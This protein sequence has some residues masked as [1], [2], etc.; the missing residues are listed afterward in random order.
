MLE[1]SI[2]LIHTGDA[3]IGWMERERWEQTQNILIEQNILKSKI[4][5]NEVYT[6]E[7][8]QKITPEQT[9]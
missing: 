6:M 4:D 2:P 7:F 8:M 1:N 5:I 3:P 9:N